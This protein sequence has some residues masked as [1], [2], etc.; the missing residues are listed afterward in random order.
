[1]NTTLITSFEIIITFASTLSLIS[2]C[3]LCCK[4]RDATPPPRAL[5]CT[6]CLSCCFFVWA[7]AA[8]PAHVPAKLRNTPQSRNAH[9]DELGTD[10]HADMIK[11][12]QPDL[13]L[14]FPAGLPSGP[15][16]ADYSVQTCGGPA[17]KL[18]HEWQDVPPADNPASRHMWL[19]HGKAAASEFSGADFFG[20]HRYRDWNTLLVLNK[21]SERFLA[22]A[23][24][25]DSGW[26]D[27]PIAHDLR[28]DNP[29]LESLMEMEWDTG[30]FPPE[31]APE[32]GD[33]TLIVGRWAFDCGHEAAPKNSPLVSTGF[34]TEIH[35]PAILISSH[36]FE[37]TPSSI[38]ARF[39]IYAGSR[40]GPL[41][42]IPLLFLFQRL[43]G[44][45]QNPLGGQDYTLN[46]GV[47]KD[48][49]KIASC[50]A[51][52]GTRASS[53]HRYITA[54]LG[55]DDGGNS[56]TLTLSAHEFN[57]S[58]RIEG[59]TIVN[60]RWVPADSLPGGGVTKCG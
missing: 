50:T 42:A 34:R 14:Q 46:L 12:K 48:G 4:A 51:Q 43:W 60:V 52:Q 32:A 38:Q 19:V 3:G 5:L 26:E 20:N 35:A 39:K 29:D 1:M 41:D 9:V 18:F 56:L 2:A 23:N 15:P 30:F 59:S 57:K 6:L 49:W 11:W 33:E 25:L 58:A 8:I 44:S 17:G 54:N 53:R 13:N 37:S 28:V 40:G 55:S 22:P 47:P 7:C 24:F 10:G 36:I 16:L 27:S 21:E 45:H 31:M